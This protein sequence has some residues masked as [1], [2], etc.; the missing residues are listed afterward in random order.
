[1]PKERSFGLDLIRCFA[2]LFVIAVQFFLNT[3]FYT[4]IKMNYGEI[5]ITLVA[6]RWL[7]YICVPLFL[8]LTGYLNYKKELNKKYYIGLKR[9]LS[10]YLFISIVTI[11]AR[12]FIFNENQAPIYWI[13]SIFNFTGI[14]IAWYV[15]M[16]IG[17]FLL[18]PFLNILYNNLTRPHKKL[19]I[20]SLIFLTSIPTFISTFK[21]LD[22]NLDIIPNY[23]LT[24]YPITYYFIGAYISEYQ[25]KYPKKRLILYLLL[26]LLFETI[27][28][29][30]FNKGQIYNWDVFGGVGSLLTVLLSVIFFILFYDI[31]INN[32]I[33]KKVISRVS[34]L[35]F[36]IYLLS[37]IT[38]RSIYSTITP[39]INRPIEY[40]LS[41]MPVIIISFI[42]SYLLSEIKNLL[43]KFVKSKKKKTIEN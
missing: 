22:M 2:V 6:M 41:I 36:D 38:D 5:I 40:L 13:I 8:L 32:E 31:K 9:I 25:I 34:I 42:M 14:G 24:I 1:M 35:S 16:Y 37:Y 11:F 4:T 28:Q 26:I 3:N 18:I 27:G 39:E 12:I 17:L 21:A 43:F 15:E 23:W 30:Y 10:S 7:F 33:I 19:L 20:F 29:I